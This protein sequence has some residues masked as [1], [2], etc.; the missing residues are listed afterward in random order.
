MPSKRTSLLVVGLLLCALTG[1]ANAAPSTEVAAS[2][3]RTN[4]LTTI[5]I[6]RADDAGEHQHTA[7]TRS[8]AI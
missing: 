2:A 3:A 5:G 6:T 8:R 7:A 4:I 1:S